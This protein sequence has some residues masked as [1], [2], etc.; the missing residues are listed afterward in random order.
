MT[1]PDAAVVVHHLTDLH[2]GPLH[3]KSSRLPFV[4]KRAEGWTHLKYYLN[5]VDA[6]RDVPDVVIV[7]GD[8]TSYA[9]DV[10]FEAAEQFLVELDR[11]LKARHASA[12][13]RICIVPGNHDL[14]WA[15]DDYGSRISR[16]H[17]MSQRLRGRVASAVAAPPEAPYIAYPD[18]NV[19]V[20]LLNSCALGGTR[21]PVIQQLRATFASLRP[22]AGEKAY[23]KALEEL[24]ALSRQDPGYVHP[25]DL[26]AVA[27]HLPPNHE[28]MLKI[29]VLHH[30]P[31][32]LPDGNIEAYESVIN[33]GQV[34]K[35]LLDHGFDVVLHGH[36]HFAHCAYEEY[37][38]EALTAPA[39]RH[40]QGLY[41][42]SGGTLGS[43]GDAGPRWF[44]MTLEDSHGAHRGQPPASRVL[45]RAARLD[46]ANESYALQ[47]E[48]SYRL[49]I[50]KPVRTSLRYLHE[51][52]GRAA[53]EADDRVR[54][55]DALD[56]IRQP[57]MKLQ[58][59]IDDWGSE[60]SWQSIFHAFLDNYGLIA[61]IDLLGPGS[62]MNPRYLDYLAQQFNARLTRLPRRKDE[63]GPVVSFCAPVIDAVRRTGWHPGYQR[64]AAAT[65]SERTPECQEL[66]I[67][68]VLL[69]GREARRERSV[70]QM[71]DSYHRLFKV[72]VFVLDP[73]HVSAEERREEF[74]LGM[75]PLLRPHHCYQ[76]V[77][78]SGRDTQEVG[79]VRA[80][81]LLERFFGFLAHPKL[82]TVQQYLE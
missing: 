66:E 39:H 33:G 7:S 79:T 56:R 50:D 34:K 82:M 67:A 8:F 80:T 12:Q 29:A 42:L 71:I 16:F 2:V 59:E 32:N 30:N 26:A 36:R 78:G 17:A 35:T 14:D 52:L 68:R 40:V 20:Y 27:R 60:S 62:W 54:A 72:P 81:M 28:R 49:V 69:W 76:Y 51:R 5:Y 64:G 19:L 41:I 44:H 77:L 65:L 74:V 38:P 11:R 63:T 48:P 31:S 18:L 25:D 75:D 21:N 57:L 22:D 53:R 46:A 23:E 43:S 6:G 24:E 73:A 4:E 37:L 10:E 47:Q 70:L 3:H 61:A 9:R 13:P 1:A 45:V 58:A 15:Q 55:R